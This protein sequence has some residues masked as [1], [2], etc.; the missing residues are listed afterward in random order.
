MNL[1]ISQKINLLTDKLEQIESKL[2]HSNF[3]LMDRDCRDLIDKRRQLM[4]DIV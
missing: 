4:A 3:E 2:L 1:I